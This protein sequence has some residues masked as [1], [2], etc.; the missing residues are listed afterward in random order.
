MV[1]KQTPSP[2]VCY[3][4]SNQQFSDNYRDCRGGFKTS[5]RQGRRKRVRVPVETL[6]S[7]PRHVADGLE[8]FTPNWK[9]LTLTCRVTWACSETVSL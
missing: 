7:G 3:K 9:L 2:D 8:I 4:S 5:R 1:E 6:F